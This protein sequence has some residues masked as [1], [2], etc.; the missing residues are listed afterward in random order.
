MIRYI[1]TDI[2]NFGKINNNYLIRIYTRLKYS[3]QKWV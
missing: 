2:K 3:N 1:F